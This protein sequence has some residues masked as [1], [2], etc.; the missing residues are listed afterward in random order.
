MMR[1]EG[2]L[3]FGEWDEIIGETK[4]NGRITQ[5]ADCTTRDCYRRTRYENSQASL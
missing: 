4:S 1:T 3:R 2:T 5:I